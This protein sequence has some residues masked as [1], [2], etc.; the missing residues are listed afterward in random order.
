MRCKVVDIAIIDTGISLNYFDNVASLES[1]V[2]FSNVN[3]I[4]ED[5]VPNNIMTH[6]TICA[7]II[8]TYA[9]AAPLH[10]LNVF[11]N[12]TSNLE[13]I[14]TAV[15]YC[16]KRNIK[17]VNISFGTNYIKND[18]GLENVTTLAADKGIILIASASKNGIVTYPAHY[19]SVISVGVKT[20]LHLSKNIIKVNEN[21][22][23][24]INVFACGIQRLY[25]DTHLIHVTANEPS[26]ATAVVTALAYKV[27][28]DSNE[29]ATR[30]KVLEMLNNNEYCGGTNCEQY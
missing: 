18:A 22:F 8:R 12:G 17:I 15:H 30:L 1:N 29:E 5:G 14:I 26:Y 4:R 28:C 27:L 23:S 7:S 24:S 21:T 13:S 3:R 11:I 25:K 9:P 6:G 20:E 10:S 2:N 16:I 19:N